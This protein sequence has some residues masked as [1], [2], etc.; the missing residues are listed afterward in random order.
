MVIASERLVVDVVSAAVEVMTG[1]VDGGE[2]PA[3]CSSKI[4]CPSAAPL[5]CAVK[6]LR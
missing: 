1:A 6:L 3:A 5:D 2:I 4:G